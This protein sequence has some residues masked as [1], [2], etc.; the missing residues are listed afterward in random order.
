MTDDAPTASREA[1]ALRA[2]CAADPENVLPRLVYADWLDE[3][4]TERTTALAHFIRCDIELDGAAGGGFSECPHCGGTGR[5]YFYTG[6]GNHEEGGCWWCDT[7]RAALLTESEAGWHAAG[8]WH[9]EEHSY[10]ESTV[11]TRQWDATAARHG[12][13]YALESGRAILIV[14]RGMVETVVA[15]NVDWWC[16]ARCYWCGGAGRPDGR[17]GL[18][19]RGRTPVP[20]SNREGAR[21][22]TAPA[23]RAPGGAST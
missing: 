7:R 5:V 3:A 22:A 10:P 17:T 9:L 2:A 19:A 11:P 15:P 20:S 8:P 12:K 4:G 21:P 6:D 16:G 1:L 18:P 13:E 14:R 23:A